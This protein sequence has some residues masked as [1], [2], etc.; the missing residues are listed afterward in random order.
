MN[1]PICMQIDSFFF[2]FV[3]WAP[4]LQLMC[5]YSN[6]ALIIS[7]YLDFCK[8]IL[9]QK[10]YFICCRNAFDM[11]AIR[12]TTGFCPQF[13]EL[14]DSLT[15]KE[16]L[17]FYAK[18]KVSLIVINLIFLNYVKNLFVFPFILTTAYVYNVTHKIL[19]VRF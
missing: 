17:T 4:R 2:L 19:H 15:P 11:A 5:L 3:A 1:Q 10:S 8:I 18:I 9:F 6:L 16:H 7:S 12:S 13:D 14:Y